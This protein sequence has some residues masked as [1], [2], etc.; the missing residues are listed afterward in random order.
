MRTMPAEVTPVNLPER[1]YVLIFMFFALSAFAISIA[2]ITQSFFKLS[3]RKKNFNEEYVALRLHL[4]KTKV[5]EDVQGRVKSYLNHLF[6]RRRIQAKEANLLNVLP[7]KLRE[8]VFRC[9]AAHH[10]EKALPALHGFRRSQRLR[11][12]AAAATCDLMPGEVLVETGALIDAAWI[13]MSGQLHRDGWNV[14]EEFPVV[15]HA[16]CLEHETCEYANCK[17]VATEISEVLK[18][19]KATFLKLVKNLR[20]SKQHD[21]VYEARKP[22]LKRSMSAISEDRTSMWDGSD[23]AIMR[24]SVAVM[25]TS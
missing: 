14:E 24:A 19:D 5:S 9:Q 12:A 22:E 20:G 4:Q 7:E 10:M 11:L 25:S 23:E 3:E 2:L 18:V 1:V 6:D 21:P 13:L 8:E 16:E 15:V 17:V